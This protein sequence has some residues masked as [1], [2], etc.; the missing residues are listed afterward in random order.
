MIFDILRC[1]SINFDILLRYKK[2]LVNFNFQDNIIIGFVKL[3][4]NFRPINIVRPAIGV[5]KF[6]L[7]LF[8][9]FIV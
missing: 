6:Q 7:G 8:N 2:L 9:F 3:E 4:R 5:K 1:I